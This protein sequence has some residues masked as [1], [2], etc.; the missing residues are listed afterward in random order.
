MQPVHSS[1][2][3]SR[4]MMGQKESS[5]GKGRIWDECLFPV[6]QSG[7]QTFRLIVSYHCQHKNKACDLPM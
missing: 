5:L 1:C 3:L 2:S 7:A 6:G 4:P